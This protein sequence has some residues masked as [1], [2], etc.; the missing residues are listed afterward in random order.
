M[1]GHFTSDLFGFLRDLEANN[2]RDWFNAN[3]DRYIESV[4]E[5]ALQFITDF[6]SRLARISPHFRADARVQGG[7]LFRIYRDTRFSNDKTPYKTNTGMHF[8]HERSKDAHAPGYYLHLE[9]GECFMGVG[10]WRPETKVAYQIREA[11][12]AD[13]SGWKKAAYG[14]RFTDV[15]SL[16]GESLQRPPKGFD[17]EHPHIEDLKRKSFMASTRLTQKQVTS[18]AFIDDFEAYAKRAT[19]FMAFLCGAVGVDF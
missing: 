16:A 5:P 19:P 10:L 7:S 8:R 6:G 2:E 15:Y 3:K 14:K 12:A 4:Q 17:P 11:I 13:P 1:P 18:D 9:P